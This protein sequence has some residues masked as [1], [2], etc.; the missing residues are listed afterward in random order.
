MHFIC[1]NEGIIDPL[2][3]VRAHLQSHVQLQPVSLV[4][5]GEGLC[6]W[7]MTRWQGPGLCP[8]W[9]NSEP[10]WEGLSLEGFPD[11]VILEM[12]SSALVTDVFLL[13]GHD[14]A[15]TFLVLFHSSF[16]R[17]CW[18]IPASY[19]IARFNGLSSPAS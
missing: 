6:S 8:S 17:L 10:G 18:L 16:G 15:S 2:E 4:T 19:R 12:V 13:L 5:R 1:F 7:N 9:P 11:K 3:L 14:S